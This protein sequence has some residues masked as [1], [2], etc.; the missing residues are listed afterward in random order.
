MFEPEELYSEMVHPF[1]QELPVTISESAIHTFPFLSIA[2]PQ[3]SESWLSVYPVEGL[4]GEPVG[5]NLLMLFDPPAPV[6]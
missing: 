6:D 4:I 5:L 2:I 3:G 1:P